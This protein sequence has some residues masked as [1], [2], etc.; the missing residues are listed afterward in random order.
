MT[1]RSA[2][3]AVAEVSAPHGVRG[4]LR[5]H[6]YDPD[7]QALRPGLKVELRPR[8]GPAGHVPSDL[9]FEIVR[10]EPVPGKATVRVQLAGVTDRDQA[11][12]LRGRE[13]YVARSDL[14]ALADDEFYL[15]DTVGLPVERVRDDGSVQRLGVVVGVTSNGAQD[16]LEVEWTRPDGRRDTWLLP[17]LPQFIGDLDGERLRVELPLGLLPDVLEAGGEA[18]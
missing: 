10:V 7:S 3:I 18:S 17:A 5:F 14:P 2:A 15:A 16:L 9:S 1:G 13:V 6:L 12:R 8:G 11:E 4:L